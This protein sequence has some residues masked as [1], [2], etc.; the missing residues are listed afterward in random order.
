MLHGKGDY[1]KVIPLYCLWLFL[2]HLTNMPNH[3]QVVLLFTLQVVI[4]PL[5]H[6]LSNPPQEA[7]HNL[8]QEELEAHL[9]LVHLVGVV[10]V[11]HLEEENHLMALV[12]LVLPIVVHLLGKDLETSLKP[13][14]P[15]VIESI[16]MDNYPPS[17]YIN[18]LSCVTYS[19]QE[20]NTWLTHSFMHLT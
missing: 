12:P 17:W 10:E 4:N 7:L 3:H 1:V 9:M 19:W 11:V 6:H 5:I 8:P 13:E 16:G 2:G 20:P 18:R 15:L 14:H